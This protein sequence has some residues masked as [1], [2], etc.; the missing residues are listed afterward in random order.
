VSKVINFNAG[1]AAVSAE[2]LSKVHE[3][4]FDYRGTG[5][6]ILESSHRSPEY[7]EINE[8][9]MALTRE[10]FGLS[11]DYH[12]LFV[13][14]GASSQFALIPMNF[15]GENQVGAY[16]DTGT[17]STK[18]YQ[19]C[20]KIGQTKVVYSGKEIDY[21]KVPAPNKIIIPEKQHDQR[22]AVF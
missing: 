16:I 12:V 14:G 1:P 20:Q 13:T 7:D 2:V 5:I 19:E 9:C 8:Q 4:L 17:W 15:L 21:S 6:S 10:L 11:E 3:E 22:D 18:A